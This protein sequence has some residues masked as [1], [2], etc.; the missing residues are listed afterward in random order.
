MAMKKFR[1]VDHFMDEV[2]Y[3]PAELL[4]LRKILVSLEL[5]ETLKWSLPC[6]CHE[7]KNVVGLG[8]F[9]SYFGLWFFQGALLKDTASVLM[10]A[11]EGKT[12]AMRQ[13][14][15][16]SAKEI[17][18]RLIKQYVLEAVQLAAAGK[19]IK[20][21]RNQPVEVHPLL[22]AAFADHPAAAKIFDSMTKGRQ[23][24]YANYITEA[25]REDT[26]LRRIAK[27][28]PMILAGGGL[29]DRYR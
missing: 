19:D 13:W 2:E 26:K 23:R 9:K 16:T 14:R 27:I 24:E 29:N 20:P 22:Q 17:K 3:F 18:V 12:K 7:G 28:I 4:K 5:D 25:K 15:M 1:S 10:N 21:N 8:A 11:Q 6:Y